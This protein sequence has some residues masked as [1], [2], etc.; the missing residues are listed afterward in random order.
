MSSSQS[1]H[2]PLLPGIVTHGPAGRG[3]YALDRLLPPDLLPEIASFFRIRVT[4]LFGHR[5]PLDNR[6]LEDL[7]DCRP[8]HCDVKLSEREIRDMQ[9]AI[10]AAGSRWRDAALETFRALVVSRARTFEAHGFGRIEPYA[11]ARPPMDPAAE[12][13]ALVE[14]FAQDPLFTPGVAQYV[15][16]HTRPA[17]D[18]E[19]FLYWSKDLFGDAKPIISVTQM[20]IVRGARH[21]PTIVAATQVYATHYLN[22]SLSLMAISGCPGEQGRYLVYTRRSRADVFGGAFGGMVRR[23]VNKRVRAEGAP[24]LDGLR[25]TL[26][27][28]PAAKDR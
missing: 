25:R 13:Q 21:E 19:S 6:D 8:G 7:K 2:Q 12:F 28:G 9:A 3:R 10:R 27:R 22:A 5:F 18:V 26:E 11:D 24:V 16:A 17:P 15:G 1:Q 20:S 4:G 23:V 14:G